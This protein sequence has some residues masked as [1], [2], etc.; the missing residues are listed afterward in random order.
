MKKSEHLQE[1]RKRW[2]FLVLCAVAAGVFLSHRK[3]HMAKE[4]LR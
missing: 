1:G 2:P 3:S 4:E